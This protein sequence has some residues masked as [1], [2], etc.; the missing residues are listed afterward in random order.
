[1]TTHEEVNEFVEQHYEAANA[2]AVQNQLPGIWHVARPILSV[3]S[4][5][6]LI[7]KK[8]RV[9]LTGLVSTVDALLEASN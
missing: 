4:S 8:W 1:M 3:L 6:P 9:I 2:A 7:P 5:F